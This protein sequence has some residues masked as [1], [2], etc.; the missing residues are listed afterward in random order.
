MDSRFVFSLGEKKERTKSDEYRSLVHRYLKPR[1]YERFLPVELTGRRPTQTASHAHIIFSEIDSSPSPPLLDDEPKREK[2]ELPFDRVQ[3]VK[4]TGF[5]DRFI[6]MNEKKLRKS[7]VRGEI[8][9]RMKNEQEGHTDDE[10][11]FQ[12]QR[13][14]ASPRTKIKLPVI[15]KLRL[16]EQWDGLRS[17]RE[18]VMSRKKAM[19]E[20]YYDCLTERL[21]KKSAVEA[22][23]VFNWKKDRIRQV[24]LRLGRMWATNVVQAMAA[25]KLSRV[26][27]WKREQALQKLKEQRYAIVLQNFLIYRICSKSLRRKIA[28]RMRAQVVIER[29][30]RVLRAR[31][32]VQQAQR[33]MGLINMF[34]RDL[35]QF[36][37][38]KLAVKKFRLQVVKMQRVYRSFRKVNVMRENL[39]LLRWEQLSETLLSE[40]QARLTS[41]KGKM[42]SILTARWNK[43][44][45]RPPSGKKSAGRSPRLPA[46]SPRIKAATLRPSKG[47]QTGEK[48]DLLSGDELRKSL[49]VLQEWDDAEKEAKTIEERMRFV[50]HIP[51]EVKRAIVRP[52]LKLKLKRQAAELAEYKKQFEVFTM[53]QNHRQLLEDAVR[54]VRGGLEGKEELVEAALTKWV[55]RQKQLPVRPTLA[56]CFQR[57]EFEKFI[58]FIYASKNN[59][60]VLP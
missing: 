22:T 35:H 18:S 54:S 5:M 11:Q 4:M 47:R 37:K 1:I 9:A 52:Y 26:M 41:L 45:H 51:D 56:I 44:A 19:E 15:P 59:S 49:Q 42:E 31:V 3:Y 10:T 34:L 20:E 8:V 36:N 57:E 53:Y 21:K 29:L 43:D 28:R 48:E 40:M 38:T 60:P 24:L 46:Q 39:L 6:F 32:K 17:H 55:G 23:G 2:K 33:A 30:I 14:V 58:E 12:R 7:T 50:R 27:I 25:N 13:Q 16:K